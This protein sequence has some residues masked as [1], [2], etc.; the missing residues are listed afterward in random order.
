MRQAN[1]APSPRLFARS[2]TIGIHGGG[3]LFPKTPGKD[4]FSKPERRAMLYGRDRIS[5]LKKMLATGPDQNMNPLHALSLPGLEDII[6]QSDQLV[7]YVSNHASI[8]QCINVSFEAQLRPWVEAM[9]MHESIA[10]DQ[11]CSIEDIP[12]G[13]YDHLIMKMPAYPH[14]P[15]LHGSVRFLMIMSDPGLFWRGWG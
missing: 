13:E 7:S 3:Q 14:L 8:N 5:K 15:Q 2:R 11:Q 1:I 9:A 6:R 4:G 12:L 10:K